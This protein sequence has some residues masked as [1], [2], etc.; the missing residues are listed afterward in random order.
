M[1]EVDRLSTMVTE[2]LA[3]SEAGEARSPDASTDPL[4][5]GAAGRHA[6]GRA[7]RADRRRGR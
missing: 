3:L 4:R 5:R 6:L 1:A 2:L 7:W